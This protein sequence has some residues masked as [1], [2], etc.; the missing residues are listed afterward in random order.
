M[1][2]I[3]VLGAGSAGVCTALEL[4]HRGHTVDLYD[5]NSAVVTQASRNNEGKVHLGLVY[6]RDGSEKT[7]QTMVLGAIHFSEYLHRWTGF[8]DWDDVLSTPYYY[9]VHKGSMSNL[10]ELEQH[11]HLC[12]RLFEDAC[13][14]TG[15][16]YL[17][18]N[19]R[20]L[21]VERVAHTELESMLSPDYF[22]AAFRTSER[23]VDPRAIADLLAAA[24]A[25]EPRIRFF[26]STRVTGASWQGNDRIRVALRAADGHERG[27]VYDR[28][29]NALWDGRLAI[30]AALGL[31]PERSW[32]YRY[33]MGGWIPQPV[34]AASD[35][36]SLTMVLGPF[37]DTVNFGARGLYFSW[38]PSGLAGVSHDLAPSKAWDLTEQSRSAILQTSYEELARRIPALGSAS[39]TGVHAAPA[40]GV[41]FAW[42]NSGIDEPRSH[43]HTRHEIGV[44]STGP[45]YHSINTGKYTMAPYLGYQAA[46]RVLGA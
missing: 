32:I 19:D 4:A 9:A 20:T 40:G 5:E 42:G 14:A 22:T 3:A 37:G 8:D 34:A 38:Y 2:R 30:D 36:P 24:V 15:L 25:S 39:P 35:I 31:K 6:A 44:Y 41:I 23:A 45:C 11:Y 46:K 1:M 29:V 21:Q 16:K 43:L 17:G 18:S 10:V 13:S 28:V 7:A 27:E 12:R 26:G 33:K